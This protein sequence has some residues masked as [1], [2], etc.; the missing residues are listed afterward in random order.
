MINK[1]FYGFLFFFCF[2]ALIS[3]EERQNENSSS[4]SKLRTEDFYLKKIVSLDTMS[5]DTKI[6]VLDTLLL[7]FNSDENYKK[8]NIYFLL[9][10]IESRYALKQDSI[11][12][13][14]DS[15]KPSEN[16][17]INVRKFSEESKFKTENLGIISFEL[18][19]EILK[20]INYAEVN[21]SIFTYYLYDDLAKIYFNNDD[22]EKSIKYTNLYFENHPLKSNL[23][24]QQR[25]FDIRFFL[26]QHT[27]NSDDMKTYLEKAKKL[28]LQIN[29][30]IAIARTFDYESQYY[31]HV[32]DH[33]NA[34][35]SSHKS[36]NFFKRNGL[37]KYH[38]FHNLSTSYMNANQ[39]DSAIFYLNKGYD[40]VKENKLATDLSVYYRNL[41][42]LY[43]EKGDL[44]K[45]LDAQDSL[46]KITEENHLKIQNQKISELETQ[47][48]TEKKDAEIQVLQETNQLNKD[49]IIQQRWLLLAG[50]LIMLSI[51]FFIYNTYSKKLL[52]EKNEK[53]EIEKK[54]YLIEQKARQSQ[55]NPHFIYNAIANMQGLIIADKKSEANVYLVALSKH[56]RNMLELNRLEYVTLDEKINAI[57]NY[58]KLQQLRYEDVFDYKINVHVHSDDLLIPPMIVQP[59]IE[60]SIEH[61]FKNINYK[62]YLEI[63]I[64]EQENQLYI[65]IVDNGSGKGI[66]SP[67][68]KKSL[69]RIITQERL[70]LIYNTN[71]KKNAY[72]VAKPLD[73]NGA[74]GY[75]VEIFL[76]L[77]RS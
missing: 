67:M 42:L 53:L 54:R 36:F 46:Y 72:F 31:N 4:Y 66:Q 71:G 73:E 6:N 56:I 60:N 15:I 44:K 16:V 24:V 1:L 57:E 76:P 51:L 75:I 5:N 62:G 11:E 29:D 22:F 12:I 26:A 8:T 13:Y 33:V 3:C 18:V 20:A 27:Y 52:K 64:E 58:V 17:D 19:E 23:F 2:L 74:R 30:S 47:F 69:S 43:R 39:I 68:G 38:H 77:I 28:A 50:I 14:L 59:F 70:D 40:F 35:K 65:K 49:L 21:N 10:A 32:G 63:D 48:E 7:D 9:K 45:A 25:Y 34:I 55:L 37:L 41:K 61:G